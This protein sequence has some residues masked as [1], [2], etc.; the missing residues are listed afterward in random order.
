ML[1][2]RLL[3]T[4]AKSLPRLLAR[5]ARIGA[6]LPGDMLFA[7]GSGL[8]NRD[9]QTISVPPVVSSLEPSE[10]QRR[11]TARRQGWRL[12]AA[13]WVCGAAAG[14]ASAGGCGASAGYV[15]ADRATF[16]AITPEYARYVETDDALSIDQKARRQRTV[17]TW[18]LR[19]RQ[20]EA[21]DATAP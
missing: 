18:R 1:G 10:R 5:T 4:V 15:A 21:A 17:Q 19:L 6:R 8:R 9:R 20:A 11:L 14:W 13:S 3:V 16:D 2:A 12:N 7:I